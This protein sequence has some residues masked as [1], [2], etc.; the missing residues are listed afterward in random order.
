MVQDRTVVVTGMGVAGGRGPLAL[1]P[2]ALVVRGDLASRRLYRPGRAG[3]P[4]Q[5]RH[6][7]C[8]RRTSSPEAAPR[9]HKMDRCVQLALE[10]AVQAH[11]DAG[12]DPRCRTHR[13]RYHR[14]HVV[15][16]DA[17]MD[18]ELKFHPVRPARDTADTRGQQ[19]A[20]LLERAPLHGTGCRRALPDGLRHVCIGSPRHRL[21]RAADHL[22]A[23]EIMMAGG[24]DAPLQDA[25]IR[26]ILATGILGSYPDPRQACR[27]FDSTR[28]GTLIGEGAAFLVLESLESARAEVR[29]STHDS[30]D[31][32]WVPTRRT[33]PRPAR[34]ARAWCRSCSERFDRKSG[35]RRDRLRQRPR[36]RHAAQRQDRGA[37][38]ARL[39]GDRVQ[40]V[41]CS[42][43]K[44]VT[45]HCLGLGG[46]G[47]RHRRPLPPAAARPA[48]G[49]LPGAGPR[50]LPQPRDRPG[51]SDEN[52][53]RDVQFPGILGQERLTDLRVLRV[54]LTGRHRLRVVMSALS[55][56]TRARTFRRRFFDLRR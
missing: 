31:G 52:A 15:R 38:H 20:R 2:S 8:R 9:S 49:E 13:A 43:T 32:P 33:A 39:L 27:P 23:A 17:E 40:Q 51:T 3:Q 36:H 48:H 53:G 34:T 11:A 16:A 1:G 46:P 26:Q 5:F 30:W 55:V 12:L 42:S 28:N 21:G 29:W 7:S 19:H 47:S 4:G 41:A 56:L 6:A 54:D 50:V 35:C 25:V 44:P 22:G 45:G 24:A 10:A 18:G 14:G 37:G